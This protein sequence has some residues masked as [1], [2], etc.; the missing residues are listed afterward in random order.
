MTQKEKM[1]MAEWNRENTTNN[2]IADYKFS[3]FQDLCKQNGLNVYCNIQDNMIQL[4]TAIIQDK[5]EI[6]YNGNVVTLEN[7]LLEY[8]TFHNLKGHCA[9]AF[10]LISKL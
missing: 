9:C 1:V 4:L 3:Q 6:R 8:A 5:K 2:D 10:N 7:L